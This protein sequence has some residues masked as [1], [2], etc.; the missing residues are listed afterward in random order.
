MLRVKR[1]ALSN[2]EYMSFG[3]S[4]PRLTVITLALV[5]QSQVFPVYPITLM[6]WTSPKIEE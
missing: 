1:C 5:T 6:P 3:H 2:Y 4:S